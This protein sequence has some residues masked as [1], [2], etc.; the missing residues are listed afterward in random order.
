MAHIRQSRPHS[1]LG[2][3]IKVLKTLCVVLSS[4]G[5]GTAYVPDDCQRDVLHVKLHDVFRSIV[6]LGV[7]T[8]LV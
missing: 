2:L 8:S 3:K 6:L 7:S 1:D 5:S 4:L